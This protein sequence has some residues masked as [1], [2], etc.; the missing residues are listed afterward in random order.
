MPIWSSRLRK[1]KTLPLN[2]AIR[3]IGVRYATALLVAGEA[4][5]FARILGPGSY[6][7]Y[8]IIIQIA[9][10]MPFVALGSSTGYVYSYFK[11]ADVSLDQYYISGALVQYVFGSFLAAAFLMA[12]KPYLTIAVTLFLIQTPY[13]I[14]EPMLRVRNRF[15]IAVLG[16]GVSSLMILALASGWLVTHKSAGQPRM[17]L[18]TAIGIMVL[19]NLFGYAAY[20][21]TVAFSGYLVVRPRALFEACLQRGNWSDYWRKVLRPGIPMNLSTVLLL[22]FSSVDR[23]FIE[24]YRQ[25]AA[26]SVYSLSWQLSQGVLLMLASL[27]LISGVRLGERLST[28]SSGVLVELYRQ[29]RIT[30]IAGVGAFALLLAG[31]SVLT[32]TV[33]PDYHDLLLLTALLGIGYIAMSVVGSITSLLVY[34]RRITTLNLGY[35]VILLASLIGNVIVIKYNLWYGAPAI[36][37]STALIVLSVWLAIYTR[38]VALKVSR[39]T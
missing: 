36:L 11:A 32:M 2:S 15:A 16:R 6:G 8:A 4:L 25:P 13:F 29:F 34:E 22:A 7:N 33:Y 27:N 20:Y 30:S 9:A 26:L 37:S 31:T 5:F 35:A 14:T 19:G 39:P 38:Q 12:F 21:L 24:H 23:L 28:D 18:S 3:F 17:E 10:L 1:L